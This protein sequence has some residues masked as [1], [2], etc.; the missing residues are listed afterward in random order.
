[1]RLSEDAW[2]TI[3]LDQERGPRWR[4]VVSRER[5]GRAGANVFGVSTRVTRGGRRRP[6]SPGLYRIVVRARDTA[7]NTS[8]DAIRR[9]HIR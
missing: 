8:G 2:V 3:H 4:R 1:L 9:F 5:A 7:G 6:L